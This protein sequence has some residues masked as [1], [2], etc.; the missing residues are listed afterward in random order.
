LNRKEEEE[1]NESLQSHLQHRRNTLICLV[2]VVVTIVAV[3][4]YYCWLS[5]QWQ[6]ICN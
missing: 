3:C 1:K 2:S 4:W 5:K 6:N